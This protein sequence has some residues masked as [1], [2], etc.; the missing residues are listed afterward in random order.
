MYA[1][2]RKRKFLGFYRFLVRRCENLPSENLWYRLR[3]QV[4]YKRLGKLDVAASRMSTRRM[5]LICIDDCYWLFF[6]TG[7]N[8]DVPGRQLMLDLSFLF[9]YHSVPQEGS[10]GLL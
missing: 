8:Y 5:G 2:A 1:D 9:F 4:D 6:R 3:R 7:P 10:G